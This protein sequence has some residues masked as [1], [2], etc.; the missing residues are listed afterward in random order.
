MKYAIK[1]IYLKPEYY[2]PR[3]RATIPG[4]WI[5]VLEDDDWFAVCGDYQASNENEVREILKNRD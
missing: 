5:A 1:E 2:N 4:A 3:L